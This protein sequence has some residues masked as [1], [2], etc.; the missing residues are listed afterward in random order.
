MPAPEGPAP[1]LPL[2][3]QARQVAALLLPTERRAALQVIGLMAASSLLDVLGLAGVVQLAVAGANPARVDHLRGINT[4]RH[5]LGNPP[6]QTLMAVALTVVGVLFLLKHAVGIIALR[7]QSRFA[8]GLARRLGVVQLRVYLAQSLLWHRQ[9]HS[10]K[11]MRNLLSVPT[12]FAQQVVLSMLM[13]IGE[14]SVALLIVVGLVVV[15]PGVVLLLVAIMGPLLWGLLGSAKRQ[16][17]HLGTL[18]AKLQPNGQRIAQEV[19][20]HIPEVQLM[21][22]E[23]VFVHALDV[24]NRRLQNTNARLYVLNQLPPRIVELGVVSG[25]IA[26]FCYAVFISGSPQALLVVLSLFAAA[27]YRLT[28][29]ANRILSS[30]IKLR[31]YRFAHLLMRDAAADHARLPAPSTVPPLPFHESVALQEVHFGYGDSAR[32]VL[33]GVSVCIKAGEHVGIS[34][35]SGAG[36]STLL[37]VL[38]G[39]IAPQSGQLQVD[40]QAVAHALLPAWRRQ[41]AYVRQDVALLDDTLAANI[42]FGDATP[43]AA[44]IAAALHAAGL[45]EWAAALPNQSRTFIGE[46]GARLS[47]GQ[48]QRLAIARALYQNARVWMFDEATSHLDADS[49]ALVLATIGQ[50][51]AAGHTVVSVS[52]RQSV[53]ATC[54]R[55]LHLHAGQL[56][57]VPP[58]T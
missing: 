33:A 25:I 30:L 47:G 31:D 53:L 26:L 49:E 37:H 57:A 10:S 23:E 18:R 2:W 29:S 54:G 21:G 52:H 40:G 46:G 41:V 7:Q 3:R 32:E 15:Q 27:A 24:H 45:A 55:V 28:P 36:K 12:E 50:L 9:H 4:I 43:D 6:H 8:F 17:G 58:A 38:M 1:R 5:W 14:G 44:R 48:R 19:L 22:R 13:L 11:L 16:A 51:V 34:G 42:A 56:A 39:L 20:Q 35:G